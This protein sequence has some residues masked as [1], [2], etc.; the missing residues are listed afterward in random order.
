MDEKQFQLSVL[1]SRLDEESSNSLSQNSNAIVHIEKALK[2]FH[3]NEKKVIF[4]V[5]CRNYSAAKCVLANLKELNA[6]LKNGQNPLLDC[7]Q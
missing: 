1:Y 5:L 6:S 2:T 7:L 4:D 3:R